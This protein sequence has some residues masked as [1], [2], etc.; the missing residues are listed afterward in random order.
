MFTSDS[1]FDYDL[2][3]YYEKLFNFEAIFHDCQFFSG[4]VHASL[5]ELN[6]LQP[7][8]K[9]RIFIS[10]YGDNWEDYLGSVGAFGFAG[11]AEQHVYYNFDN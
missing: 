6:K 4:G 1:R 3:D 8:Y 2:I 5:E 7:E 9:N 11:L 10:H